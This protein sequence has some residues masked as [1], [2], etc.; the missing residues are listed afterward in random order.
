MLLCQQLFRAKK[1]VLVLKIAELVAK[2]GK[3]AENKAIML[4][5]V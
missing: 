1:L 2:A 4:E 5:K 3:K